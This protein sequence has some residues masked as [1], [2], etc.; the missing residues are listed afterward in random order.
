MLERASRALSD[1]AGANGE[2]GWTS[3]PPTRFAQSLPLGRGRP[4]RIA[5][6]YARS[7]G[8]GFAGHHS[9]KREHQSR[10]QQVASFSCATGSACAREADHYFVTSGTAAITSGGDRLF[11]APFLPT[12]RQES[13]P[14]LRKRL[15]TQVIHADLPL[16]VR[17]RQPFD[18]HEPFGHIAEI[19]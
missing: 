6:S 16:D 11:A 12:E 2:I 3:R 18:R 8:S 10:L 9:R 5:G 17:E 1:A 4:R 19:R 13:R 15:M 14:G 7:R